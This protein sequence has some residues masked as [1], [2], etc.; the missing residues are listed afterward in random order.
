MLVLQEFL[1]GY[2][3]SEDALKELKEKYGINSR[4][5][6]DYKNLILFKYSQIDS[7]MGEKICQESRGI[8]LDE[9][10]N[11]EV[12]SRPYDKFFNVEEFHAHADEMDWNSVKTISKEDGSL[13]SL[14]FYDDKWHCA[15]SGTPDANGEVGNW[16]F[17]FKDLFWKIWKELGYNL[18]LEEDNNLTF[19]FELVGPYNTIVVKH[20]VSNIIIH[21]VRNRITGQEYSHL[22]FAQKYNWNFAKEYFFDTKEA[23][24]EGAKEL[25]GIEQEGFVVVDKDFKRVKIKNVEYIKFSRMKEGFSL[26]SVI[27]IVQENEDSEFFSYF[28]EYYEHYEQVK[29]KFSDLCKEITETYDSIKHIE[30][31]KD[32]AQEAVKNKYSGILFSLRKNKENNVK[33]LLCNMSSEKL[34]NLLGITNKLISNF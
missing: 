7:P 9:S 22:V 13:I 31:Q 1:N 32:F 12:I 15:T 5:H 26:R 3:S 23:I 17:S 30:S 34:E 20:K 18:P 27:E 14:Y 19:M 4:R 33:S 6:S 28:P 21:G 8:I 24:L 2:D 11:W 25:N 10:N 29:N 16:G